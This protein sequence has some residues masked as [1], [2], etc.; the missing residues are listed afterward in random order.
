M[1]VPVLTPP[2]EGPRE[3]GNVPGAGRDDAQGEVVVPGPVDPQLIRRHAAQRLLAGAALAALLSSIG[4]VVITSLWNKPLDVPFQY[5]HTTTDDEQDATLEMMI[6]KN[7]AETGWYLHNPNLNAPFGQ[8]WS[9]WPMGGDVAAYTV[10]KG[11]LGLTGNNVPLTDNLFWLLTFPLTAAVAYPVMRALRCSHASSVA[12]AVLFSLSPY[13]FRNGIGHENLAFYV[14]VP[15]TVWL[16]VRLMDVRDRPRRERRPRPWSIPRLDSLAWPVAGA[17]F[18]GVTGLYYLAFFLAL[19][20][21]C[22]LFTSIVFRTWKSIKLLVLFAGAALASSAL[23]NLPTLWFRATHPPNPLAVGERTATASEALGLRLS[24]LLSPIYQHRFPPF[25]RLSDLLAPSGPKG[26]ETAN[27][28]LIGA[29]GFVVLVLGLLRRVVRPDGEHAVGGRDHRSPPIDVRLACIVVFAVLI[30]TKGGLDRMLAPIGFLGIRAWVRIA[31]VIAF[32][33]IAAL[34]RVADRLYRRLRIRLERHG[35]G[36]PRVVFVTLLALVCVVGVFDQTSQAFLPHPADR[37]AAWRADDL[38]VKTL[39]RQLPRN[40]M[41]FQLPVV[42]FP[43]S[44]QRL[45]MANYDLI[46]EG[47]LHSSHLRWSAGGVR[48]RVGDWQFPAA[49]TPVPTFLDDISAVGFSGLTL[50]RWGYKD[51]GRRIIRDVTKLLGSPIVRGHNDR[52]FAWDL[53]SYASSLHARYTTTELR[54]LRDRTLYQPRVYLVHPDRQR[55]TIQNTPVGPSVA[56]VSFVVPKGFRWRGV[57]GVAAH[58]RLGATPVSVRVRAG[59]HTVLVPADGRRHWVPVDTPAGTTT[60]TIVAT[61]RN[62]DKYRALD[63][64]YRVTS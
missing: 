12:G 8:Q 51:N 45:H 64:S 34:A 46:K 7:V 58:M 62:L 38:F 43:E 44:R 2:R 15:I 14:G 39:E 35:V 4:L 24:E 57:I 27:L 41:V 54:A 29:I 18:I 28:G 36:R 56:R 59:G 5:A 60:A 10:K 31:I 53:R 25:A 61:S 49:L 42:D 48:G 32:A 26:F 20:A 21:C 11:I 33:S 47:Y 37:R 3:P 55:L 16:C 9:E 50:D 17:L 30:A 1:N 13:H 23:A 40:A 22:A 52:L 63:L 6:T 19:G